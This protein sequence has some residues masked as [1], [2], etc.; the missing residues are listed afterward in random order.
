MLILFDGEFGARQTQRFSE[1]ML[2]TG[3]WSWDLETGVMQWSRGLMEL[4][5]LEAGA[6]TPSYF[7]FEGAIHPDDKHALSDLEQML[8]SSIAV[9]REFRILNSSG[10]VRWIAL[11][12]EPVA[13]LTGRP[14]RAVGICYDVTKHREELSL[15]QRGEDRLRGFA[16]LAKELMW[17]AKPNG[18]LVKVLN[19]RDADRTHAEETATISWPSL[20]H[21]DDRPLF[22]EQWA[23][24]VASRQPLVFEHRLR[25]ADG[26]YAPYWTRA[27]PTLTANGGVQ[28][29]VGLSRNIQNSRDFYPQR[30]E[31]P[32]GIQ[33]RAGRAVIGWSVKQL[34]EAAQLSAST[35]RVLEEFDTASPKH[36]TE[37]EAIR[38]A[39]FEAGVE[40][41][42]SADGKPGVRPR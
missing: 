18:S 20:V 6:V 5:G 7:T 11:K 29:W 10:R 37:L 25:E 41:T 26:H 30:E 9:E 32:T 40:L 8:Q 34:S 42:F 35:I 12:A 38:T 36:R 23:H 19:W 39:L 13:S 22:E 14:R 27:A 31:T 21:P 15:L 28:E 2:H 17:V 33:I 24:A 16:Q 3:H 1:E 4:L